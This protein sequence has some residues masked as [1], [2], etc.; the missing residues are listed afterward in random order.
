V[1]VKGFSG[2]RLER[3]F[4]AKA[5]QRSLSPGVEAMLATVPFGYAHTPVSMNAV[6]TCLLGT[7]TYHFPHL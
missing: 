6:E 2:K 7:V 1:T 3:K 4:H 5:S